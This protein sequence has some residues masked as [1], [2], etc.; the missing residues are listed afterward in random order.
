MSVKEQNSRREYHGFTTGNTL[1]RYPQSMK[2]GN[3]P[4]SEDYQSSQFRKF[5]LE[6]DRR[7]ARGL[8]TRCGFRCLDPDRVKGKRA[9][10][11]TKGMMREKNYEFHATI[12][13]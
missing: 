13:A 7:C 1:R 5:D 6:K 10:K 11:K 3:C 8:C 4:H 9:L 2:R 12:V